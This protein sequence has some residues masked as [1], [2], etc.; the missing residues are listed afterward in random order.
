M[1]LSDLL[2]G[3]AWIVAGLLGILSGSWLAWRIFR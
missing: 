1:T 3:L 2:L